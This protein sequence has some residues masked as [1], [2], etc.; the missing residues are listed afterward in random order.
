MFRGFKILAV[1]GSLASLT[2]YSGLVYAQAG[3]TEIPP[4]E[5][6]KSDSSKVSL[7]VFE[8]R[9]TVGGYFKTIGGIQATRVASWNG[10]TWVALGTGPTNPAG[11]LVAYNDQL[12]SA[13]TSAKQSSS[14]SIVTDHFV[15]VFD[16]ENWL[17]IE[18]TLENGFVS[19]IGTKTNQIWLS[20]N[21]LDI[22][23]PGKTFTTALFSFDGISTFTEVA[24]VG[25]REKGEI[26][27]D[28]FGRII[29][30]GKINGSE[31]PGTVQ[32]TNIEQGVVRLQSNSGDNVIWNTI[33]GTLPDTMDPS[34]WIS[35]VVFDT[36]NGD[37]YLA[38][39]K[40]D[41]SLRFSTSIFRY[42]NSE[43]EWEALNWRVLG[44]SGNSSPE[45]P[46]GNLKDMLIFDNH[47]IA[48]G[49]F[50]QAGI[51]SE[52]EKAPGAYFWELP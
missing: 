22:D 38:I 29:I 31:L 21:K 11:S 27:V 26:T 3:S 47:L 32:P 6:W 36:S 10:T 15:D 48:V 16:G 28:G 19:L 4:L 14:F 35:N 44:S 24:S 17:P 51:G 37:L 25:N 52:I 23:S 1:L 45:D 33:A 40:K 43:E 8:E 12:Y 2:S 34:G 18:D 42:D 50:K 30:A 13:T 9:L 49:K 46:T 39:T 20:H 5:R 7:T 41:K